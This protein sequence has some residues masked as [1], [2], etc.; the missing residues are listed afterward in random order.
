[1]TPGLEL[2]LMELTTLQ[3]IEAL[4]DGRIDAGFGRLRFDDPQVRRDVLR[5]ERLVAALPLNHPLL[6]QQGPL[7]LRSLAK[8]PL[9]IYPNSPRPSY[10]DQVVSIFRD[11]GFEPLIAHEARELQTAIGLVAAE[12]GVCIVP[13]S[14]QRLRRDD[15]AY[16]ELDDPNATS[17]IILSRRADDRSHE[18]ILLMQA[19]LES[20]R[21]WEWPAPMGLD[22]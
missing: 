17:P 22:A 14:V 20:Y 12:V 21:Q 8:E 13:A 6:K 9:V 16:R 1:M 10:A 18:T 4:K 15:V 19:I 11:R 3:Q 7:G 5:E 2:E